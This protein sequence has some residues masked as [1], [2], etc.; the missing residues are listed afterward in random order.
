M[1]DHIPSDLIP[2]Y[3]DMVISFVNY[4][5]RVSLH[6]KTSD[7]LNAQNAAMNEFF[8]AKYAGAPPVPPPMV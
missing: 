7:E 8:S 3:D 2:I 6:Q 4:E 5:L 1:T